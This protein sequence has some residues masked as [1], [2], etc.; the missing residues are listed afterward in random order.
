MVRSWLTETVTQV[1]DLLNQINGL[2][3]EVRL[4]LLDRLVPEPEP[5]TKPTRKTRKKS[6]ASKAAIRDSLKRGQ[7]AAA[8]NNSD[9][10]GEVCTYEFPDSKGTRCGTTIDDNIHHRMSDPLFHPFVSASPAPGVAQPSSANGG[11]RATTQNS[12][13]QPENVSNVHHAGD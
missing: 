1:D 3:D 10:A 12:E 13:T 11:T 9:R 6:S 2:P 5:E 7:Q 8:L 4:Y